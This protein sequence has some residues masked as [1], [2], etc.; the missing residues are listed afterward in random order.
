[1]F[2]LMEKTKRLIISLYKQFSFVKKKKQSSD[3]LDRDYIYYKLQKLIEQAK[4][5][6]LEPNLEEIN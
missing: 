4:I 3:G 1:M 6:D 2:L 5:T